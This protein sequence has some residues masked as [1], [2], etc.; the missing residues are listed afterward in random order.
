MSNSRAGVVPSVAIVEAGAV[1]G[2]VRGALTLAVGVGA[3]T[4][5]S[6]KADDQEY[7]YASWLF[8]A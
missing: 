5:K 3:A 4:G 1:I 8:L 6:A 2:R 7:A